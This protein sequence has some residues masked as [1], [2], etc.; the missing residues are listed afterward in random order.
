[1]N[2]QVFTDTEADFEDSESE[3]SEISEIDWEEIDGQFEEKMSAR[4]VL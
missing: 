4:P 1:M 2:D 3:C